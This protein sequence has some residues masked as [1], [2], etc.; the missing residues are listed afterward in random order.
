MWN[1]NHLMKKLLRRLLG[2]ERERFSFLGRDFVS[3]STAD[4]IVTFA[5]KNWERRDRLLREQLAD[6]TSQY[7]GAKILLCVAEARL[8]MANL[9][10]RT[11]LILLSDNI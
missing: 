3:A 4:E 11:A 7:R 9:E 1:Y 8:E 10:L 6:V 2:L 5:C